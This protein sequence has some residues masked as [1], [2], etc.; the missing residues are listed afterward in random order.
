MKALAKADDFGATDADS[1]R[2]L[3]QT[4]EDHEAFLKLWEMKKS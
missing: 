3:L 2:L 4:F 1:D